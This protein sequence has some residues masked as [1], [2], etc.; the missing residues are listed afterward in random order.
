MP[1]ARITNEMTTKDIKE[2][3][4]KKGLSRK[5]KKA[6]LLKRLNDAMSS[7]ET[8][9]G[10][11]EISLTTS[12]N[13]VASSSIVSQIASEV[14][15]KAELKIKMTVLEEKQRLQIQ[16]L[17]LQMKRAKL[18]LEEQI[19]VSEARRVAL[20][21]QAEQGSTS[22]QSLRHSQ[23]RKLELQHDADRALKDEG[24][25]AISSLLTQQKRSLLPQSKLPFFDGNPL[26]YRSFIRAFESR[27]AERTN[28]CSE[29]LNFLDQFT[30]GR[31]NDIVRSYMNIDPVK[32]YEEARRAMERRYGNEHK[33]ATAYMDKILQ[34]PCIKSGEANAFDDFAVL[35]RSCL[36][37]T[38]DIS[39]LS[40]INHPK[41]LQHI[42]SKF[43]FLLQERW[44]CTVYHLN[45][46]GK[47]PNLSYLVKFVEQEVD[48][49][50][51]P[52][53]GT[54]E[55]TVFAKS[56][57][58]AQTNEQTKS[59]NRTSFS[60]KA[61]D[62]R[63]QNSDAVQEFQVNVYCLYCKGAHSIEACESLLEM[64][65]DRRLQVVRDHRLCFGCL[66]T[67][68]VSK[69]CR[70]RLQCQKCEKYHPTLLHAKKRIFGNLT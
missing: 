26:E 52:L 41:N 35:L 59:K 27:I 4:E 67:G 39:T 19:A 10:S 47:Q 57:R 55:M 6:E 44:R 20:E 1:I 32:G 24:L 22:A 40:E 8:K 68:H 53:F 65:I 29:R 38:E 56:K 63:P 70:S 16:E 2:E 46:E 7:E 33:I 18:D 36:N 12:F 25:L 17:E 69:Q 34:W 49:M 45:E 3:L 48:M 54:E 14:A 51:D 15:R 42:V 23:D 30:R 43:P 31:L 11:S 9:S 58:I 66:K 5:G 28:D 21:T 62:E 50:T 37:A 61:D 60:T 13:S 64:R